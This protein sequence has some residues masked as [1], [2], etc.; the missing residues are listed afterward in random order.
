MTQ[1]TITVSLGQLTGWTLGTVGSSELGV[2]TTLAEYV[3][4]PIT[5]RVI[6]FSIRRGRQHELDRIETGTATATLINQDGAV[7]PTNTSSVYYPD[8]RP[9]VPI[10]IQASFFNPLGITG[11]KAWY[12]FT[13]IGSLFQDTARITPIT[14]NGQTIKGV[15]DKS[16]NGNHLSEATNGPTYTVAGINGYS[17]GRFDGT[18]DTLTRAPFVGSIAQ[19]YTVFIVGQFN[20]TATVNDPAMDG[21]GGSRS[22]AV[23]VNASGQFGH[24]YGSAVIGSTVAD[25]TSPHV[26]C[27]TANGASSALRIDG[28]ANTAIGNPG[29]DTLL[30]IILANNT[31]VFAQIDFLH[32]LI[33]SGDISAADKNSLGSD[34][35]TFT[36]TTWTPVS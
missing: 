3:Y 9:M 36:G 4:T 30:G 29:T 7:T 28:G 13:D 35:A 32:L 12:D 31:A 11:L 16:G 8:I 1:P 21:T 22:H 20:D 26:F 25:D 34:L 15:T 24:Y 33:Y 17:V 27:S 14:S 18:N 5:S 23:L 10:K 2:T 6:D 19:P